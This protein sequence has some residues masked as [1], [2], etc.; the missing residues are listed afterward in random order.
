MLLSATEPA[1]RSRPLKRT[2]EHLAQ[3]YNEAKTCEGLDNGKPGRAA[4][5]LRL[6][7]AP[8]G[9]EFPEAGAVI[10]PDP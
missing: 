10:T 8:F 5:R 9:K 4:A 2:E 3:Q 7:R 6:L 1:F